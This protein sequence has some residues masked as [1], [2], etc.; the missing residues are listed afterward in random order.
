MQYTKV[1]VD[2][3]SVIYARPTLM[4]SHRRSP[5]RA[6]DELVNWLIPLADSAHGSVTIVFDGGKR[7]KPSPD[8]PQVH[9]IEI[10]YSEPGQTADS[11]IERRVAAHERRE[12]VLV[13]TNDRVEQSIVEGFG[14]ETM[15]V[16][17]FAEWLEREEAT[18]KGRLDELHREARKYRK[19]P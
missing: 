2:A 16:A 13:V 12:G 1:Y 7:A 10:V 18:L 19:F 14:A 8:R 6:R 5:Q 15:S 11:V 4:Q 17:A 3:Y 9:N